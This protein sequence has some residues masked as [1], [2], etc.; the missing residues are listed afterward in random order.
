MEEE[1]R[2][3]FKYE[4][5]I[6]PRLKGPQK[7]NFSNPY[8]RRLTD[9]VPAV[10]IGF[11]AIVGCFIGYNTYRKEFKD[12]GNSVGSSIVNAAVIVILGNIYQVL[13]KVLASWENHKFNEGWES[14]LSTKNFSF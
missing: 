2:P 1:E 12:P 4:I 14:S 5:V 7:K 3:D 10:I 9:E 11:G 8:I 6:D 13:A